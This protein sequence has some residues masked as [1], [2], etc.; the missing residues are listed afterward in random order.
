MRFATPTAAYYCGIDLYARTM[1]PVVL[2]QAGTVR[3]DRNYPIRP[4]AFLAAV[5]RGNG[6]RSP[7]RCLG[8]IARPPFGVD[9]DAVPAADSKTGVK[10]KTAT[11]FAATRER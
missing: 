7:D 9:A 11:T 8:A 1:Y 2:D 5:L 4:D 10:R 3:L 6:R